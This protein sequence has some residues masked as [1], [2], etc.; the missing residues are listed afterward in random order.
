MFNHVC[1]SATVGSGKD[2]GKYFGTTLLIIGKE[3]REKSKI[4]DKRL[5]ALVLERNVKEKEIKNE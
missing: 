1:K 4:K 2:V 3:K 5:L